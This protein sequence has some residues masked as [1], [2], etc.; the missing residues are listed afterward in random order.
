MSDRSYSIRACDYADAVLDGTIPACLFV[1][2]ACERFIKDLDR[3][4]IYL[5]DE[6]DRWCRYLEKLPHTKGKWA[7]K[8]EKFK[9]GDWKIFCTVN[10][11][12]GLRTLTHRRGVRDR[13]ILPSQ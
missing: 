1:R 12:G 13:Y 6:G 8:K 9:L 4:D 7:A 11:Y 2:L 3:T 5:S 10:L